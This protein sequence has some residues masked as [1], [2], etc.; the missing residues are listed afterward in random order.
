MTIPGFS[1]LDS[2]VATLAGAIGK[3]DG[4]LKFSNF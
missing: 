3:P 1:Y 2:V 4:N